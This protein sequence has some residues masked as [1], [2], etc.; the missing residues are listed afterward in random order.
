MRGMGLMAGFVIVAMV[1]FGACSGGDAQGEQG[2]E[3][4]KE[5][6]DTWMSELSNWGRWGEDDQLGALNLITPAKRIE[7]AALVRDGRTTDSFGSVTRL[8]TM[9]AR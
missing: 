5:Q 9:A 7:A 3:V 1:A 2:A 8:N 6:Y 4:T